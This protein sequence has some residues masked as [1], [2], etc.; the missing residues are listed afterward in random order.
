[1][2]F[3][4]SPIDG[5]T[6]NNNGV[7]YVYSAGLGVWNINGTTSIGSP[8][9][10]VSGRQ[11]AV[12]LTAADIGGGTYPS[13]DR[14]ISGNVIVIGGNIV[15]GSGAAS[16]STT[17]GALVVSGG[18][19]ANGAAYIGGTLTV[20]GAVTVSGGLT[21]T[22]VTASGGLTAAT[23]SISSGIN[24][25]IIGASA[26]AAGT[27]TALTATGTFTGVAANY[28]GS[29]TYSANNKLTFGPNSSWSQYLQVGGNGIDGSYAQIAATNGNLHL[30][31]LGASY[32]IY[33]NFYRAGGVNAN[34]FLNVTGAIT[35]TT[36]ITAYYSDERLK[37]KIGKIE[38]ALDKIDELSGFLYVEN[39]LARSLGFKNTE[40]Q[41]ALS[42]QAVNLVQPEAVS[43][44]PFDRDKDGASK[45]GE[46]YLTVNYERLIPLLVEGIKEL[47][48]ELNN[49]KKQLK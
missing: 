17:T 13:G 35:A 11:G 2:A 15:A 43:I 25:T 31:S 23:L 19:G 41:V 42:A 20:T 26:A 27:F 9:T 4:V 7:N 30:E 21:T 24:S 3:P 12:T 5:Q 29:A 39:D 1:M 36:T 34:G 33:L 44:A 10:S 47:R 6:Y 48:Q 18:I 37:T 22:N 45:S 32:P 38:N 16:T 8:V 46:N 40:Q 14:T 49:I 28:S